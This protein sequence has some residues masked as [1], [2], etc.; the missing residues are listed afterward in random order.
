ML[1]RNIKLGVTRTREVSASLGVRFTYTYERVSRVATKMA[2]FGPDDDGRNTLPEGIDFGLG[3][4]DYMMGVEAMLPD[5]RRKCVLVLD[6]LKQVYKGMLQQVGKRGIWSV[7]CFPKQNSEAF[8]QLLR[9]RVPQAL[10]MLAYYC[11][12]LDQLDARWWVNGRASRVVRNV[13]EAV[14]ERWRSWID[15][16]VQAVLMKREMEPWTD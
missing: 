3:H 7:L 2:L 16:P 6:E 15:W 14:D 4:L 12:L 13:V 5:D 9:R 1:N 11:V 8:E 10:V